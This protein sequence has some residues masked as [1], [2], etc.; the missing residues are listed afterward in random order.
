M[1][2]LINFYSNKLQRKENLLSKLQLKAN[3]LDYEMSVNETISL[4]VLQ[5]EVRLLKEVIE[6]MKEAEP[7]K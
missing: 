7:V 2:N 6:D 1:T 4:N 3:D 5:A